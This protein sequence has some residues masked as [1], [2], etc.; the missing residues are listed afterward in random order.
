V[1]S[2][3]AAR[4]QPWAAA[5]VC[6]AALAVAY[7]WPLA[8]RLSSVFPHDAFDPALN[9][10]ILW[11]NAH[12]VPLTARWWN[13]PF[14]WP[15]QGTLALSEHLLGVS[16]LTTPLQWA[17]VGP[18]ASYNVALIASFALAALAAHALVVAVTGRHD[19]A[20][21][22]GLAYGFSFYR[23]DQL[24]HLQVLWSFGMPLALAAAHVYVRAG[25]ARWLALFGAS[26]LVQAL[27]NGYFLLFFPILLALWLL[28]H[29][30]SA[31]GTGARR[32]AWELAGAWL[33]ASVPLVPIL[34][35]YHRVQTHLHLGR[36]INEIE[37]FSADL[38]AL[39]A[40]PVDSIS[41]H[42]LSG[43]ER[44][45]GAL[46][47]GAVVLALVAAGV[48][49]AAMRPYD[50]ADETPWIRPV[51][52]GLAI[53][54]AA[55]TA[56][57]LSVVVFGPW[58]I[59][60]G[61][62]AIVSV[63]RFDK[64]LTVGLYL[65]G[66]AFVLGPRV[67]ALRRRGSEL[68]FYT[69]AGLAM[70]V[71][72]LGPKPRLAGH[73]VLFHAPYSALLALPGFDG[74][75]VPAR[76]GTLVDLCLVA[77]AGI[78]FSQLTRRWSSRSRRAAAAIAALVIVVE[79]RPV[80]RIVPAPHPADAFERLA[81]GSVV[82]ELPLGA[83]DRDVA[84]MYRAMDHGHPTVN[85][86]SG[87]EPPHYLVLKIALARG[88]VAALDAAAGG[89]TMFVGVERGPELEHWST[90]MSRG[91]RHRIVSD[92]RRWRVYQIDPLAADPPPAATR[93][94][95]AHVAANLNERDVARLADG[96]IWTLWNAGQLQRGNETVTI[97]L[98]QER[99]VDSVRLELGPY[100]YDFPRELEVD[101]AGADESWLPCWHE[102]AAAL[103]VRGILD[104]PEHA[105]MTIPIGRPGVRKLRLR[106]TAVDDKNGWSIA[107]LAV[108]GR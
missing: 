12:V 63:G 73:P 9:T 52:R 87:Y 107:E 31:I 19:A 25:G 51:R 65:L 41:W 11:W 77:A 84:A 17:G 78:A 32:R 26:W 64:P 39:F 106:Q 40:A 85:G 104:D 72:A 56:V 100:I 70:F 90:L 102:S 3:R 93:L 36:S 67:R 4:W 76:I 8:T 91:P 101:C 61:S 42:V 48:L 10:W 95:L 108:F 33:V 55:M 45:E 74:L 81:P 16:V 80:F 86:Y 89:R 94:P 92:D 38:T 103:L 53:A 18:V 99:T 6:Y 88:D 34:V 27:A 97:D 28:W 13:A 49:A 68:A 15:E 23:L 5:A 58:R 21:I 83:T 37:S 98:G 22:A 7:T 24:P 2:S 50:S 35:V 14:F 44:P 69:L 82:V 57:A 75:R 60:T 47:P 1:D 29:G 62:R 71:L 30:S 20:A 43:F 96:D 105:P 66:A 54:G 79:L 59:G 46:F